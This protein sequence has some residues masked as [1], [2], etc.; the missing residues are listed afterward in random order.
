V[1]LALL[2]VVAGCDDDPTD[3]GVPDLAGDFAVTPDTLGVQEAIRVVFNRPVE[4]GTALDPANFVV[5]NLCDTLRVPGAVRLSGDTLIFSPSQPLPFLTLLSVRVQNILDAQ[6]NALRQPIVFQRITEA[7][8]VSDVSW[9]FQNSP[10]ND[11]VTGV[12]FENPDVGYLVT[13]GGSVYRTLN[14]GAIF[15]ARFKNP[16]ITETYNI[17][18]FGGDTVLMIGSILVGG[19][20]QWTVFRS[21]DSALTFQP[22][23]TVGVLLYGSRFRRVGTE[24]VGVVGGQSLAPALYRYRASTHT[25]SVSTGTP[26]TGSELFTDIALSEDT[27]KA[28]ATF[29]N[30]FTNRGLAYRSLDGGASYTAMTL[31]ADTRNLFGTGFVDNNT[32][33]L[34]GDSS[35]VFRVDVA[36]GT[37]TRLGAA[38]GIPQ[39]E[40]AGTASTIFTFTRAR[41]APDGQLGWITGFVTR[42]R[43]GSADV[44]QGVILQSRD[45]GQ[46]WTRQAIAGA[47]EDGL[48]FPPVRALQAL[49]RDFAALSGD[50]GLVAARTDDTRPAAAACSFT[51]P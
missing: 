16:N 49:S 51:Q 32:A 28:V 23:N 22:A 13:F 45:G 12:N 3:P 4:A 50:N 36:G 18:T 26:N 38:Q 6:G 9:D 24:V 2:A 10:T 8:P 7:P 31:P 21:L 39:T 34:L 40:I 17:Q 20:P 46:T 47:P 30:F 41:F 25:L 15:G 44:V 1:A 48:G 19:S 14:G 35:E 43:P 27:T 42:R 11:F 37:V 29:F 33:L 5:T